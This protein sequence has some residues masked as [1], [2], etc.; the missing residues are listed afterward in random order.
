MPAPNRLLHT[1][2]RLHTHTHTLPHRRTHT[3]PAKLLFINT[4]PP[5]PRMRNV[6]TFPPPSNNNN[7]LC[8]YK[9]FK[10]HLNFP[11]KRDCSEES[12][13]TVNSTTCVSFLLFTL[14]LRSRKMS[15]DQSF[16]YYIPLNKQAKRGFSQRH[17]LFMSSITTC[18]E[19]HN[20]ISRKKK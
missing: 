19:A 9:Q 12:T 4:Y 5:F 1:Q 8:T 2:T 17:R 16:L 7:I 20:L 15:F 14:N 10:I 11:R 13:T 18:T 3:F 6:C